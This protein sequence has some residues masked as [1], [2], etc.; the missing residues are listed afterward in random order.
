MD[1]P[2]FRPASARSRS[3]SGY[4]SR[5]ERR[6]RVEA[7]LEVRDRDLLVALVR[8]RSLARAVVVRVDALL[9]ELRDGR[10]RLLRRDAEAA[11]CDQALRMTVRQRGR[12]RGRVA[13]DLDLPVRNELAQP[14]L[15]LLARPAG[16]VAEVE[17]DGRL[18]RDDVRGDA[19]LDPDGAH[20]LAIHESI[21]LDIE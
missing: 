6:E 18:G 17:L 15:R 4:A 12:G 19:A 20:D 2:P 14:C 16:R 1:R 5:Q 21:E 13:E 8:I 7:A 3:S 10:P 11:E 9:R